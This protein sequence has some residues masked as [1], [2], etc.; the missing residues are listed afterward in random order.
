M[1]PQRSPFKDENRVRIKE[2]KERKSACK[3]NHNA[4]VS[5]GKKNLNNCT[6]VERIEIRQ[7]KEPG[8]SLRAE[9]IRIEIG[10]IVTFSPRLDS[11]PNNDCRGMS[12][13]CA[14]DSFGEL[15]EVKL[16]TRTLRS[17]IIRIF[18]IISSEIACA[19]FFHRLTRRVID[20]NRDCET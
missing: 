17:Y 1:V 19:A 6:R 9:S 8:L 3:F 15:R 13:T 11:L 14:T 2:K 4:M 7:E 5:F 18:I 16:P 20:D 10:T 12:F